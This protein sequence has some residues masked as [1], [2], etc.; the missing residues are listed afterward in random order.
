MC[1]FVGFF[2]KIDRK[3]IGDLKLAT[4]L[5]KHRGPDDT[6]YF[7]SEKIALGFNRLSIQDLSKRG[8]QP[9]FSS[10]KR[11]VIAFNGEIYNFKE[12]RNIINYNGIQ[13][14][15]NSD[16]EILV[17]LYQIYKEKVFSKIRGMFSFVIFD[18]KENSLLLARDS[19]GIKPLYYISQKKNFAFS[20]ELKGFIPFIGKNLNW[21]INDKFLHEQLIYRSV[22]NGNTLIKDVKKILPGHYL[23]LHR[24][25]KTLRKFNSYEENQ[26]KDKP[27][28]LDQI[29]KN[30]IKQHL[31]SDVPTGIALSGG[32]DSSLLTALTNDIQKKRIKTFSITFNEKN[33]SNK[34]VDESNYINYVV[35][36]FKTIHHKK[37]LTEDIYVKNYLHCLWHN[38][39]PIHFPHTPGINLLSKLAESK[40]VK[41]LLGGEGAD[42]IFAGYNSFLNK[43]NNYELFRYSNP[44]LVR[45][46]LRYKEIYSK[47][48]KSDGD[49]KSLKSK[50]NFSIQTHLQNLTN[51]LDKMS[52]AE[53]IEFRTPFLD[54]EVFNFS[55][56]LNKNE[57]IKKGVTK[58]CLKSIAKNYFK[59]KFIYRPKVGFSIPLNKWLKNKKGLGD[60]VSILTED[61][62]LNRS[63]YNKKEL[64]IFLE[65]YLKKKDDLNDHFSDSGLIWNLLN[66]E[67]WIR[68]FVEE[69]RKISI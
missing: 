35:K 25:K 32:I 26:L 13:L 49:K 10:N 16:T 7:I 64:K 30:S 28:N 54:K 20:S 51:R 12:L 42:E 59:N 3:I 55:K 17:N 15:S 37:I 43:K 44:L 45:K 56:N 63:F 68:M 29:L 36:K 52:M 58:Y 69:K 53:G 21:E 23:K 27:D 66:L 62:A 2:G 6:K 34:V 5:T 1:G 48:I 14:K 57:F 60:I 47:I 65:N 31:I 24:N 50:I 33:L 18:K 39:E 4:N 9:M 11:Y 40:G 22:S 41:V 19:F 8:S 61:R 67:L 46:I 38:D